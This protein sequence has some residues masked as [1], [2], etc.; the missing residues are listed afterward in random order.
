MTLHIITNSPAETMALG[1]RF[2]AVLTAGDV[3]LLS[4]HLGAGKT[5]FVSGVAEGLG[6]TERVTSPTFVI[7][8]IYTDGFLPLVHADVYRLS[9]LAEFE[10]LEITDDAIGGVTIIEWGDAI[11]DGVGPDRL[12][13]HVDIEGDRRRFTFEPSGTWSSRSLEMLT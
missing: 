13:V 6:I 2:A 7:A 12:T 8:R 11:A 3:V 9:T 1:R 4:G 5:V 10:D